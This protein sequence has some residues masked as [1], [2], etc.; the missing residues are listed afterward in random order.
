MEKKNVTLIL[1]VV[2]TAFGI[3]RVSQGTQGQDLD[4][5]TATLLLRQPFSTQSLIWFAHY[6]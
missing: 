1:Q 5:H 6:L 3:D 4:Y 2:E